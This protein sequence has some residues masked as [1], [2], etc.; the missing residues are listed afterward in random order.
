MPRNI[1]A[2]GFGEDEKDKRR[3]ALAEKS[4]ARRGR[5]RGVFKTIGQGIDA[6]GRVAS[7][8]SP[9]GLMRSL[10]TRDEQ[11]LADVRGT[12]EGVADA[13]LS[14]VA[15]VEDLVGLDADAKALREFELTGFMG[16]R[17]PEAS[18][19]GRAVGR[20]GS[21]LGLTLAGAGAIGKIPQIAKLTRVPRE[22]ARFGPVDFLFGLDEESSAIAALPDKAV[23]DVIQKNPILRALA[24]AT[25][26]GGLGFGIE[27]R[28]LK[29]EAAEAGK[30]ARRGGKRTLEDEFRRLEGQT[31]MFDTPET[32]HQADVGAPTFVDPETGLPQQPPLAQRSLET[33]VR[34]YTDGEPANP[35]EREILR[36]ASENNISIDDARQIINRGRGIVD[37][38]EPFERA[39][40]G[41][42][43][44]LPASALVD[45]SFEFVDDIPVQTSIHDPESVAMW[46]ENPHQNID[47]LETVFRQEGESVA[48]ARIHALLDHHELIGDTPQ[49][50]ID[51]ILKDL[52]EAGRSDISDELI[53]QMINRNVPTEDFNKILRR[54]SM[55]GPLDSTLED[56]ARDLSD[57]LQLRGFDDTSSFIKTPADQLPKGAEDF[58]VRPKVN[59]EGELVV[60]EFRGSFLDQDGQ[61]VPASGSYFENEG[62]IDVSG[63]GMADAFFGP[64]TKDMMRNPG[65]RTLRKHIKFLHRQFPD[66]RQLTFNR[67]GSTGGEHG[68]DVVINLR[69]LRD[70]G[71]THEALLRAV[72]GGGAGGLAGAALDPD[73]PFRGA[74]IGALAG[75]GGTAVLARG[76][77]KLRK[78]FAKGSLTDSELA[79]REV[80]DFEARQLD[81]L[82][83]QGDLFPHDIDPVAAVSMKH[84]EKNIDVEDIVQRILNRQAPNINLGG[85]DKAVDTGARLV[86]D[87]RVDARSIPNSALQAA[88]ERIGLADHEIIRRA[89]NEADMTRAQAQ[90][91]VNE[92]STLAEQLAK[93]EQILGKV[94]GRVPQESFDAL[95]SLYNSLSRKYDEG[96]SDLL[97]LGSARGR[98]LQAMKVRALEHAT[99]DP[100]N[101]TPWVMHARRLSKDKFTSVDVAK[102]R[103]FLAKGDKA[104]MRD[105]MRIMETRGLNWGEKAG[106][107]IKAGLLSAPKTDMINVGTVVI[108]QG[109]RALSSPV[110]VAADR[111][112]KILT[113]NRSVVIKA[114]GEGTWID[115]SGGMPKIGEG[116]DWGLHGNEKIGAKGFKQAWA[117]K[118]ASRDAFN[119]FDFR[120][121][122]TGNKFLDGYL[123]WGF[124]R[125]S[126]EDA[127]M[128][129]AI[130]HSSMMSRAKAMGKTAGLKGDALKKY[131][132]DMMT[133]MPDDIVIPSLAEAEIMTFTN[134]AVLGDAINSFKQRLIDSGSAG[135][136]AAELG[137]PFVN[138]L[139]NVF[140]TVLRHT[141]AGLLRKP[142]RSEVSNLMKV[143]FKANGAELTTEGQRA[144]AQA[145][146]DMSLGGAL[147]AGGW[148]MRDKGWMTGSF[149]DDS[150]KNLFAQSNAQALAVR[151]GK[152][153]VS[154]EN[155]TPAGNLIALGAMLRDAFEDEDADMNVSNLL[156]GSF[157]ALSN[158]MTELTFLANVETAMNALADPGRAGT[159]FGEALGK[160]A[161]PTVLRQASAALDP[162]FR[163]SDPE[164]FATGFGGGIRETTPF[165]RGLPAQIDRIT[166]EDRSR[167]KVAETLPG[168]LVENLLNPVR[169]SELT[170]DP[171]ARE[172][173]RLNVP[174]PKLTTVKRRDVVG[175]DREELERVYGRELNEAVSKKLESRSFKRK[176][177]EEKRVILKRLVTKTRTATTKRLTKEEQLPEAEKKKIEDTFFTKG[178]GGSAEAKPNPFAPKK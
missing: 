150:K 76:A 37:P 56:F 146:G 86:L 115:F 35:F 91:A 16:D 48:G 128:K 177:D 104:G 129:G 173:T 28:L 94:Q 98:D 50:T 144:L 151:L 84:T 106:Q 96:V 99:F 141:P 49:R 5:H 75:I 130:L 120:G 156:A 101:V 147:L 92:L 108:N 85:V 105:F 100:S 164:G 109:G 78:V 72:V 11:G 155:V 110:A 61:S 97:K 172:L 93:T 127:M 157:A 139:V 58:R 60:T 54:V 34:P 38:T 136:L 169:I 160:M 140:D 19:A 126:S 7:N 23:P 15:A 29:R 81:D 13:P 148:F 25:A 83:E 87:K 131:V 1:F 158:Q 165:S 162:V 143:M 114:P 107:F 31:D 22:V 154:L 4:A 135:A 47:R 24:E 43:E 138:T 27:R 52:E 176:T 2:P 168:R 174:V 57:H 77:G 6:A 119:K 95:N 170:S 171:V 21:E 9:T 67:A 20:V 123:Q 133:E 124:V 103:D 122:R 149:P 46:R 41:P 132:S 59:D 79:L 53:S 30:A 116:L 8:I 137:I 14:L 71:Y 74:A 12:V 152:Y 134:Q 64:I 90:A 65:F 112:M 55:D 89:I 33:P 159:T 39:V 40:G 26:F 45:D 175:R 88:A 82:I 73:D 111:L 10:L 80:A 17:L 166:G 51:S 69:P 113:G 63:L 18:V 142:V 118:G 62:I 68:R 3:A 178:F 163:E 153:S 70:R 42:Q 44:M 145:F 117:A 121:I 36:L 161:V 66:A 125:L 102:I 32:L 167:K